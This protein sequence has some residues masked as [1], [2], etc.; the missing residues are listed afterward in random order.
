MI[1]RNCNFSEKTRNITKSFTKRS[2]N[3][4]E[5][6]TT[7]Y[8][9]IIIMGR[10]EECHA[11]TVIFKSKS[12]DSPPALETTLKSISFLLR[13]CLSVF[14]GQFNSK[15]I[16]LVAFWRTWSSTY[17]WLKCNSTRI[18]K[19]RLMQISKLFAEL[20]L[21]LMQDLDL[22]VCF[23]PLLWFKL[24]RTYSTR[25]ICWNFLNFFFCWNFE[26]FAKLSNL[27]LASEFI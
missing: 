13:S 8:H 11:M 12:T 10:A 6:W 18:I 15:L 1:H 17:L 25:R 24:W 4:L 14:V 23:V 21:S 20:I 19:I 22:S 16:K 2:R 3:N 9:M 7:I 27:H 26:I 5:V